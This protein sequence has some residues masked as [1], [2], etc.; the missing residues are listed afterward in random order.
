MVVNCGFKPS[1]QRCLLRL[2]NRSSDVE[3]HSLRSTPS[4]EHTTPLLSGA[5]ES[6]TALDGYTSDESN[7]SKSSKESA[8]SKHDDSV[9]LPPGKDEDSGQV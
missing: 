3:V 8:N 7:K 5:S 4:S 6:E 1:E 2:S 9:S